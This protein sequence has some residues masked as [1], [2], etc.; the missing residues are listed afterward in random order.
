MQTTSERESSLMKFTLCAHPQFV[1]LVDKAAARTFSNR[2]EYIR[3]ALMLAMRNDGY[4]K[5]GDLA[6]V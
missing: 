2:S 3:R 6:S 1:S 4:L 5:E